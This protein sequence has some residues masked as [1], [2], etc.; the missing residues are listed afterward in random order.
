MVEA[1]QEDRLFDY[2]EGDHGGP[3]WQE[4]YVCLR[5]NGAYGSV[6]IKKKHAAGAKA[7]DE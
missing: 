7:D 1:E 4:N 6:W 5:D 2:D 3:Y